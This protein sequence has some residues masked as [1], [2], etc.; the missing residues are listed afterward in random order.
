VLIPHIILMFAALIVVLRAALG[1]VLGERSLGRFVPW[2]LLLMVP[3]G[4]V[5]G[6]VVQK[7]AFGAFWTGWPFGE[8]WTD[9]KTLA[10][11]VVWVLAGLVCRYWPRLDRGAILLAS[12]VM[13]AVY[14]IPHSVHG[15]ELDWSQVEQGVE[16]TRPG[17][18]GG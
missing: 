8:D 15:S 5:L 6:P 10:A 11:V 14:L 7:L 16:D 9:N 2:V 12:A 17:S 3:G 13:L 18:A 4:L 1:A